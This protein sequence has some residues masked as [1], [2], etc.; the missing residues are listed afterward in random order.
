M[1]V[2]RA[3]LLRLACMP[4]KYKQASPDFPQQSPTDQFYNQAQWESYRKLG[5]WIAEQIFSA[6]EAPDRWVPR[7]MFE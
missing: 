6:P 2:S 5:D 1:R 7:M 3:E 4:L